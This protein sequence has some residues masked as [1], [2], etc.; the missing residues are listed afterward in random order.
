MIS[1]LVGVYIYEYKKKD[2][3]NEKTTF[4]YYQDK[5]EIKKAIEEKNKKEDQ[6]T[7]I[8]IY[9]SSLFVLNSKKN[10]I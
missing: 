3:P 7:M 5:K 4:D 10:L 2:N 9:Q 1:I 8:L 6:K